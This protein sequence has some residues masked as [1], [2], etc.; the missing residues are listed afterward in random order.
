MNE[1]EIATEG[2][3]SFIADRDRGGTRRGRGRRFAGATVRV[4]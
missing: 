2:S 4:E 3:K 1:A